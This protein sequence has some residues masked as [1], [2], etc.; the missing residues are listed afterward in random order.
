[1]I[2][3]VDVHD[4]PEE[5]VKAIQK[6]VE[7]FR[8]DEETRKVKEQEPEKIDFL[9]KPMGNIKGTLGRKEIYDF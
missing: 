3:K 7:L 9:S 8:Q 2:D 4:L 6:I 1:M 5:K